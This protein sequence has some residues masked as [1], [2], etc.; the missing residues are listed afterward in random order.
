MPDPEHAG[1]RSTLSAAGPGDGTPWWMTWPVLATLACGLISL[2]WVIALPSLPSFD[3]FSWILWGREIVDSG[4]NFQTNGG[5]SWKPL[6]VLFTSVFGL[7]GD[8]APDLWMVVARTGGLLALAAAF[9]L[10]QRVAGSF[11]GLIAV[12][13]LFLTTE[14]L[15]NLQ[16]GTSEPTL[17]ALVLWALIAHLNGRRNIAFALGVAAG[18]L[19]PEV[20]PFIGLYALWIGRPTGWPA[21][22]LLV[23]GLLLIPLLWFVPPWV[24]SDDP[25]NAS[26][27]AA[28]YDG[29]LGSNPALTVI[30]R[31][32]H[33]AA[34][35]FMVAALIALILAVRA[36]E[37][38]SLA[39]GLGALAWVAVVVVTTVAAGFPGLP[40]FMLPATAIVCVL[41]GVGAVRLVALA[42]GRRIGGLIA[43]LLLAGAV[44]G[45]LGRIDDLSPQYYD[46]QHANAN[47]RA[48]D[49]AVNRAGGRALILRCSHRLVATN[50]AIRIALAW[51]LKVEMLVVRPYVRH[52]A[53]VFRGPHVVTL[54][55]APK[56]SYRP[57]SIYQIARTKVWHV[58]G[59]LPAGKRPAPGCPRTA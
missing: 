49:L 30:E 9:R 14:W 58:F 12:V 10:S 33:L 37:R 35:P 31:F 54:G 2:V 53:I 5:P 25:F 13:G 21:R 20:W 42:P 15:R 50:Q 4:L 1:A 16:R 41:A 43:L 19:R 22:A 32:G 56:L 28:S 55:A 45:S 40:R 7:F 39:L 46:V 27:H 3:P 51:K 26:S 59:V 6:P 8:A 17:V 18:L 48:L 34:V 47:Y 29:A 24:A 57:R 36:R 44:A 52:P 11:A 23:G 38:L